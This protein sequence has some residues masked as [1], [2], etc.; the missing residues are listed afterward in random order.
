[1]LSSF[2][3]RIVSISRVFGIGVSLAVAVPGIDPLIDPGTEGEP[4]LEPTG[5]SVSL[6]SFF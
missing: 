3:S 6:Y 1:M 2:Y 4:G 5:E